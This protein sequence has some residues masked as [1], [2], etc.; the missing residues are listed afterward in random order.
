M[1]FRIKQ[2]EYKDGSKSY[3]IQSRFLF[4]WS[5]MKSRRDN[6]SYC[7]FGLKDATEQLNELRGSE[8]SK[9]KMLDI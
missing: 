8:V 1:N 6:S 4:F 5:D 7:F 2:I 3:Q 9:V